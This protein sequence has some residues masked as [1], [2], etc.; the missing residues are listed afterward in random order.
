MSAPILPGFFP[1][2]SICR[3]NDTYYLVTSS[4]EYVP[5]IPI[6]SSVDLLNWEPIGHAVPDPRAIHA[7]SG[8]SGASQGLFAPTIR[9]HD[10][11][12][13]VTTTS[14]QDVARGQLLVS[15]SD[16]RGPWSEP[17]YV[18]GT[19]GID[20]DLTWDED[21]TCLLTWRSFFPGGIRQVAIDPMSGARLGDERALWSGS[22]LSDTEAPHL[23]R[24]GDWWY[25]I[26]AEGGT[27]LGHA[28]SVA[29][30]RSPR[31]PFESHPR[32]PI[33][34]HRSTA[35]EVQGTGHADL[36]ELADGTW[37]MVYLGIRQ[38]GA[39]PGFHVLGRETYLAG[40]EWQDDWPVV[41]PERFAL[42]VGDHSFCDDLT[43]EPLHPRW[44]APSISPGDVV[45]PGGRLARS[46]DAGSSE[47]TRVLCTR[48]RD[49]SWE[50]I[51]EFEGDGCLSVRIDA[52]HWYG[53]ESE[54]NSARARGV[55][56]AF[57]RVSDRVRLRDGDRLAVRAVAQHVEFSNDGGP[58][59]IHLGVQ[60]A[61]DFME[62]AR[63]D[64]RYLSTEV[65][66]GFTGRVIGV[67]SLGYATAV[68]AVEYRSLG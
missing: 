38:A 46:R 28:V 21:G 35:N 52:D 16:P 15:A 13:H 11:R 50:A 31:G 58:D 25:L 65:A 14:I 54:G 19:P 51:A 23:I 17:V 26:V 30:S 34:S 18:E 68:R 55:V 7:E 49:R 6:H 36:L 27:H 29:R 61:E 10:G 9:Y 63:F 41:T 24:R 45:S 42:N 2:P 4:F 47:G 32:N 53:V 57:E 20:P 67:E 56:G 39:F 1:D 59:T 43:A 48:V 40:A 22:G 60:R 12:F 64:G 62:V 8:R 66:G 37:A 33:F 44:I 5:G 3:A